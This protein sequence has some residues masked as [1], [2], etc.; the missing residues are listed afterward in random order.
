MP[1][2][3]RMEDFDIEET[4]NKLGVLWTWDFDPSSRQPIYTILRAEELQETVPMMP[5]WEP[6]SANWS[7]KGGVFKNKFLMDPRRRPPWPKR[8]QCLD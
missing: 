6:N 4:N 3:K 8:C 5:H 7:I 1:C 2:E